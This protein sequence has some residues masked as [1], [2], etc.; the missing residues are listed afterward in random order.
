MGSGCPQGLLSRTLRPYLGLGFLTVNKGDNN[1]TSQIWERLGE[2][3]H[4][5]QGRVAWH[6]LG[7][8]EEQR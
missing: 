1:A 6:R 3:I 4:L 7:L 8:C 2:S 5:K